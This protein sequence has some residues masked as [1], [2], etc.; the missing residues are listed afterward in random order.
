MN[1]NHHVVA[2]LYGRLIRTTPTVFAVDGDPTVR[3]TAELLITAAGW[4][5]RIFACAEEFLAYPRV[6]APSCLIL[7]AT[8]PD[9][10]SLHVQKHV[11]DRMEMPIIFIA[12]R[13]DVGMAVRAMKA[14]ALEFLMKPCGDE[15]LLAVIRCAIDRSRAALSRHAWIQA[16]RRR[17]SS[18]SARERDVM[19]LVAEGNLNKQIG[20]VLGISEVTVKSHRGRVMQKMGAG[21]LPELVNMAMKLELISSQMDIRV[22]ADERRSA[23]RMLEYHLLSPA[24]QAPSPA[25]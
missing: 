21:S 5:P 2:R 7:S 12:E 17:Y 11:R 25:S 4:R 6:L 22:T 9:L 3:R 15:Q 24:S 18:L 20:G 10:G 14:G 19:A 23:H 8:L 16:L 1:S 13:A